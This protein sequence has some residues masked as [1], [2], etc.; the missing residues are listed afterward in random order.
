MLT[1][2]T[3]S[4]LFM[5]VGIGCGAD[6]G[7]PDLQ[8]PGSSEYAAEPQLPDGVQCYGTEPSFEHV[9]AFQQCVM[10]HAA[11]KTGAARGY[12]PSDVNFD[13]RAAAE[14]QATHAVIVVM[15]GI[16]PP[17]AS[18]LTLTAAEKQQLYDWAMC[19]M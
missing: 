1:R 13:T 4:T 7:G 16:M 8:Q 12:A 15:T 3:C 14:A 18:G 9:T 6:S 10:C 17:R 11:T 5:L 2:L 19:T